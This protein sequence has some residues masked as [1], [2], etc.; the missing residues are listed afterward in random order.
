MLS[1]SLGSFRHLLSS[2]IFHIECSCT[3]RIICWGN[4]KSSTLANHILRRLISNGMN[5]PSVSASVKRQASDWIHWNTLWRLK[6]GGRGDRFPRVTMYTMG[7]NLTLDA[8]ADARC[9]HPFNVQHL[10]RC[11]SAGKLF[12]CLTY[13]SLWGEYEE[14]E[15]EDESN[16][17]LD[18]EEVEGCWKDDVRQMHIW[19][20][21]C[22]TTIQHAKN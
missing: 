8:A 9:V 19:K 21:T 12:E 3:W 10:R 15:E 16:S 7:S 4:R 5:T 18:V 11:V 14:D 6:I 20:S 13:L 1:I 2:L 22:V 17:S